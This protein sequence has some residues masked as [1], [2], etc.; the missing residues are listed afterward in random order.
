MQLQQL[1]NL[2]E[3]ESLHF[4]APEP[5]LTFLNYLTYGYMIDNV[6]LILAGVLHGRDVKARPHI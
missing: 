2:N 6:V 5:L 3:M 4:Q 1:L